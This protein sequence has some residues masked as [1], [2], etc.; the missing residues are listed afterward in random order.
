MKPE[1][2]NWS[3]N[4]ALGWT[5]ESGHMEYDGAKLPWTMWRKGLANKGNDTMPNYYG[6]L[7]ACHEMEK[8]LNAEIS[9]Y[10]EYLT[11]GDDDYEGC[12]KAMMAT[13]PQ[14]C[15]SFL[16]VI[17]KWREPTSDSVTPEAVTDPNPV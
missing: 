13:A 12:Y 14:R 15:E 8:V 17:G 4:E 1:E 7:N 10:F 6:D 9:T 3:I 5:P 11:K 16:R 2:I